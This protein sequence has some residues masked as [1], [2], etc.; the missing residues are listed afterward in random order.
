V[1]GLVSHSR[2][3]RI[4]R[5][6]GLDP[7]IFDRQITQESGRRKH[8][9]S[10][11]GARGPAQIMPET[12]KGLGVN[13]YDADVTDDLEGAARL[14]RDLLHQFGGSYE[15]ALRAYNAGPGAVEKSK[16][17]AETN[18]YVARIL[19]DKRPEL[20]PDK[21]RA[22]HG[23]GATPDQEISLGPGFGQP[24]RESAVLD[25]LQSADQD[26]LKLARDVQ[27]ADAVK[28]ETVTLQGQEASADP[29]RHDVSETGTDVHLPAGLE[30]LGEESNRLA[31]KMGFTAGSHQRSAQHNADVGGAADSDHLE[32]GDRWA[33]DYPATG[34][35]GR[36]AAIRMAERFGIKGWDGEGIAERTFK[37]GKHKVRV[38]VIY[39]KSVDHGDHFHVGFRR[40]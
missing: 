33:T 20:S 23:A 4:A 37:S 32:K 17:Y 40:L 21:A 24:T 29:P 36:A 35:H 31:R 10:G 34:E 25:W 14:M 39:G 13:L 12:A 3:H 18:D 26:P 15:K 6:Y 7:E 1:S 28:D 9:V 16:Q 5:R 19:G 38:Q 22:G 30:K 11:A 27:N 8:A 2:L